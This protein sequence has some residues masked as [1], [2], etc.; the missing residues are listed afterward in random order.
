MYAVG[1]GLH[2]DAYLSNLAVET[3]NTNQ[4]YIGGSIFPV[5]PVAK[6]SDRYHVI[7]T[8]DFLRELEHRRAPRTAANAVDWKY[9]S[10]AYICE[11]YALQHKIALEDISNHDEQLRLRETGVRLLSSL[12]GL[13]EEIRIASTVTSA[14]NNGG[15]FSATGV[16]SVQKWSVATADIIGQVNTAHANI[17]AKT[18]LVANTMVVDWDTW[19]NLKRNVGIL[20]LYNSSNNGL[21]NDQQIRDTLRVENIYVGKAVKN[22]SAA[23]QPVASMT[24]VW[25]HNCWLG[26]VNPTVTGLRVLTYGL[27]MRWSPS[28]FPAPMAVQVSRDDGAG[29]THTEI[30]EAGYYQAEKVIGKNFGYL[31]SNTL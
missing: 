20:S 4:D 12:L 1:R 15:S 13:G 29:S 27:R 6:M 18:G 2:Y 5:V 21:L 10:D 9:S 26:Y 30:M 19:T 22:V 25:G 28:T 31:I 23:G 14:S 3:F 17:R 11:N 8:E 16:N 7:E 24:N